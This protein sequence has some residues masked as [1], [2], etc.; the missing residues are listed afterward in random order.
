MSKEISYYKTLYEFGRGGIRRG[1]GVCFVA[2]V[3][4][5]HGPLLMC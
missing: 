3:Q 2:Q 4:I 1:E 5:P